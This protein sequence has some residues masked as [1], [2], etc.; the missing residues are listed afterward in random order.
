MDGAVPAAGGPELE[1]AGVAPE[2]AA[3]ADTAPV[4]ALVAAGI[5]VAAAAAAV[6]TGQI[7]SF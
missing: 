4:P 1:P 7:W 2:L 3:A 5:G 6:A